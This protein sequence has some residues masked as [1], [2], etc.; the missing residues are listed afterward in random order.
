[1]GGEDRGAILDARR[2][3]R[4]PA[5]HRVGRHRCRDRHPCRASCTRRD[6]RP[7]RVRRLV[8]VAPPGRAHRGASYRRCRRRLPSLSRGPAPSA[9]QTD[10][11]DAG[12]L[13]RPAGARRWTYRPARPCRPLRPLLGC[14]FARYPRRHCSIVCWGVRGRSLAR[15]HRRTGRF[16]R[17]RPDCQAS[18]RSPTCHRACPCRTSTAA[19]RSPHA[20]SGAVDPTMAL[21]NRSAGSP[22]RRAPAPRPVRQRPVRSWNRPRAGQK[23]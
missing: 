16:V 22:W 11:W 7:C 19:E 21:V 8:R 15:A 18:R 17:H 4:V 6:R 9:D 5:P 2:P 20:R 1:M 13:G 12:Q 23:P 10:P 14:Q 3:R